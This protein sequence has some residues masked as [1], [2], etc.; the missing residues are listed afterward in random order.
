MDDGDYIQGKEFI[1]TQ[2]QEIFQKINPQEA[3]TQNA[4]KE[5]IKKNLQEIENI[6]TQN[7]KITQKMLLL[8]DLDEETRQ[9]A[10]ETKQANRKRITNLEKQN[11][12]LQNK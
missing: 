4:I 10:E 8:D 5:Q 6:N 9:I 3:D 1:F 12:I 2:L 11:D 7:K